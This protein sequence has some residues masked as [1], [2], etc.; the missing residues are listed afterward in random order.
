MTNLISQSH[1]KFRHSDFSARFKNQSKN[2]QNHL[3]T[4]SDHASWRYKLY[5]SL[6]E[7]R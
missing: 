7:E 1:E 3:P 2:P 5:N 6:F 4:R